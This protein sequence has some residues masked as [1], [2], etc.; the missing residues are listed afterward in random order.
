MKGKRD[1]IREA[2][3]E[4]GKQAERGKASLVREGA[5]GPNRAERKKKIKRGKGWGLGWRILGQPIAPSLCPASAH[6]PPVLIA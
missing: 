6:L 4:C 1:E 2:E 3:K 5:K